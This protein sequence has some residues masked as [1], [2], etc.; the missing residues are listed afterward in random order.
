[1][2]PFLYNV[3]TSYRY[4]E[5]ADMDDPWGH[6]N[7]LEW[8]TSCP[9]P[10]HNF[11]SIPRI[12][13]ERPAFDYHYPHVVSGNGD[14]DQ[15][16]YAITGAMSRRTTPDRARGLRYLTPAPGRRICAEAYADAVRAPAASTAS[17]APATVRNTVGA[18]SISSCRVAMV[19]TSMGHRRTCLVWFGLPAG[20]SNLYPPRRLG[21][22]RRA[23]ARDSRFAYA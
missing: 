16:R 14:V 7:S 11:T 21:N 10:R 19:G 5:I 15:R 23:R 1:M 12:R 20:T 6:G 4:G 3:Y 2:V 18:D 8:A 22:R 9:P 17:T 13:S